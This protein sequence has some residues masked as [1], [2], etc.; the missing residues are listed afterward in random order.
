MA[1]CGISSPETATVTEPAG[2][3]AAEDFGAEESLLEAD[4]EVLL[5]GFEEVPDEWGG[6]LRD[7]LDGA[8]AAVA[9]VEA[10]SVPRSGEDPIA[11][12]HPPSSTAVAARAAAR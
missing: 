1:G 6:V 2:F 8:R 7:A 9:A 5:V 11:E 4:A 3:G 12:E 10:A